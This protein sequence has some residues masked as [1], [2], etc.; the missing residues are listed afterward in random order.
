MKRRKKADDH[1]R[2][3]AKRMAER[4]NNRKVHPFK[5]GDAVT[6][7]I[8]R[9]DCAAT[10][11]HRLP[12]IV[13]QQLGKKLL[14]YRLQ[15]EYGVLNTTF[16]GSELELYSGAVKVDAHGWE[17][18]PKI[19]LREA[20]KKANPNNIFYGMSCC[21]KKGCGK[22]CS[23]RQSGKPCSTH[24]HSGRSCQNCR[25]INPASRTS[26]AR[27][28]DYHSSSQLLKHSL[29]QDEQ[30]REEGEK[31]CCHK[32]REPGD[33]RKREGCWKKDRG[34]LYS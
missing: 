34:T 7:R 29:E 31:C 26:P 23:C 32:K 24:C 30:R 21:C 13:V 6:V 1:Y 16:P 9:I 19:G 27:A 17:T 2:L 15:S 14:L 10:D 11:L 22:K 5:V 18:A 4:Y 3:N 25:D 20:A 33:F 28:D 8:P 12:C